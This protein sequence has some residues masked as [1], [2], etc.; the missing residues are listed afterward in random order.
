M[1]KISYM[2]M[3][4]IPIIFSSS[5]L[6]THAAGTTQWRSYSDIAINKEW[7]ITFNQAIAANSISD[8]VY[9]MDSNN[10]KIAI[11]VSV[12]SNVLNVK[13]KEDLNYSTAPVAASHQFQ[14][15]PSQLHPPKH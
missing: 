5:L 10:N 4:I 8:N 14:A 6:V 1:K 7:T 2:M 11:T 12:S 13:P 15:N 3:V 9:L